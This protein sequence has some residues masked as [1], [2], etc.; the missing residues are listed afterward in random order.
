ME[1]KNKDI[2]KYRNLVYSYALYKTGDFTLADDITSQSINLF[3]LKVNNLDAIDIKKWFIE[4]CKNYCKKAIDRKIR[5]YKI[6]QNYKTELISR[7][8]QHSKTEKD[9]ELLAS[10]KTVYNHLSAADLRLLLFYFKCGNNVKEMSRISSESYEA[11]RKR[12]Y[13]LKKSL[14]AATFQNLGIITSKKL[15]SPSLNTHVINFFKEFK[16]NLEN[17]TLHKMYYYF[18]EIDLK[19]YNPDVQIK[20]LVDYEINITNNIYTAHVIFKN[21]DNE[22]QSFYIKFHIKGKNRLKI[23]TPPTPDNLHFF[24]FNRESGKQLIKLLEQ[25]PENREGYSKIPKELIAKIIK[26]SSREN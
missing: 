8:N 4:T 16:E 5:I 3:L 11:L 12:V 2:I 1:I 19:K 24:S 9:H 6:N 23:I 7:I 13:R 14:K 26:D 21:Y 22:P 15:I 25:Y 17:R 18:S 10:F 20:E